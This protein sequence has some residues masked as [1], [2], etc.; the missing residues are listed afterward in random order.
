MKAL[1]APLTLWPTLETPAARQE[2]LVGAEFLPYLQTYR[3]VAALFVV[4]IHCP[5]LLTQEHEVSWLT[6]LFSRST[7]LFVFMSG[8]IFQHL[9]PG[10]KPRRYYKS[11]VKNVLLPYTVLS[12]AYLAYK[13]CVTK[14]VPSLSVA[15][16]EYVTG[17]VLM[18]YWFVPMLCL[19]YLAAPLLLR[20]DR[21]GRVYYALPA[22]MVVSLLVHRGYVP[23]GNSLGMF[24]HFFSVYLLGMFCSRHKEAV[25]RITHAHRYTLAVA[26]VCMFFTEHMAPKFFV[27]QLQYVQKVLLTFMLLY[28]F[29]RY[30]HWV[31]K[32]LKRLADISFGIYLLHSFVILFLQHVLNYVVHD[33][34]LAYNSGYY[35][36][37][38]LLVMVLTVALIKATKLVLR[39]RSRYLIGC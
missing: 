34:K 21:D 25:Y 33:I 19:F 13:L 26:L 9:S 4:S 27:E 31:P 28:V 22:F 12:F 14:T 16:L 32:A 24:T 1:Y 29:R 30:D 7:L 23:Q 6:L 15:A 2:A 8:F 38:L 36:A 20:L 18:P 10:F 3:A 35:V 37:I 39:R 5:M 11:K 17:D